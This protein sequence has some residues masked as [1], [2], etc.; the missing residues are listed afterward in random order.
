M[1]QLTGRFAPLFRQI[2]GFGR[3]LASPSNYRIGR[4]QTGTTGRIYSV[5]GNTP[6]KNFIRGVINAAG[7]ANLIDFFIPDSILSTFNLDDIGGLFGGDQAMHP[8]PVVKSWSTPTA[9]FVKLQDGRGG[10]QKADGT[11]TYYRYPKSTPIYASGARNLKDML[12]ADRALERQMRA[13]KKAV[14]RRFPA[15]PRRA[16]KVN[17]IKESGAGELIIAK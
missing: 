13:V 6:I 17:V 2:P 8:S 1:W 7:V 15:K 3:Y 10:A 16:P 9:N 5:A 11:W 14:D 4:T 12:K